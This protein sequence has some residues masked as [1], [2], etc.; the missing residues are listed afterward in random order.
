[1]KFVLRILGGLG[2]QLFQYGTMRYLNLKY[3]GSEMYIDARNYEKFKLRN[4][5]MKEFVCYD[6]IKDYLDNPIK[7]TLAR[8]GYHVYQYLY[9]RL[10]HVQAPMLGSFFAKRGLVCATVDFEMPTEFNTDI[11]FLYGYFGKIKYIKEIKDVLA[12]DLQLKNPLS[13]KAEK[14]MK[15]IKESKNAVGVSVRYGMDYRSLGWPICTP[16]F[17]RSGMD[18]LREQRTDCKFFVFSDVLDEV[19]ENKWFEDYDVEFVSGCPVVESFMLLRACR[20]FVVA[21]S[22]FSWW[23]AWLAE[24]EGKI[25]YAPNYFFTEKYHHRYDELIVYDEERFLDYKTGE[26]TKAPKFEE[27]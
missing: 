20:D 17:Y 6:N 23:A 27:R 9:H 24:G 21:N 3:P 11:V 22:S 12:K 5:E 16:E 15:M 14:Y 2:N 25:V 13:E 1:M 4:F 18:K 10:C 8:E 19:K 7:Y 26:P